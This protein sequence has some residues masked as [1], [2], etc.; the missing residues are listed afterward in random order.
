MAIRHAPRSGKQLIKEALMARLYATIDRQRSRRLEEL[1]IKNALIGGFSHKSF[2]YKGEV[3]NADT[4]PPPRIRIR[5]LPEFWPQVDEW[6]A[7]EVERTMV[8]EPVISAGLNRI[9]NA[10]SDA[11]DVLLIL[12]ESLHNSVKPYMMALVSDKR[13]S[14]DKIEDIK[15]A[16]AHSL[17]RMYERMALNLII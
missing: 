12:P 7:E 8:E 1:A 15:A 2:V 9:L 14:S 6:L 10:C 5:L 17:E 4:T 16:N 11:R 13:L 3:Y